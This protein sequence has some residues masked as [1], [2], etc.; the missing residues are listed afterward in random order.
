MN[1]ETMPTNSSHTQDGTTN[2]G[3]SIEP[4]YL[5]S[6]S[7]FQFKNYE[8]IQLHF[9]SPIVC[10]LGNN[11]EGKTNL[12]DAIHYLSFTKSYFH[13]TDAL[14]VRH[15]CDQASVTGEFVRANQPE[16]LHC[17]IRKNQRKIVKRNHK[18]Y[19]RLAEHIGLL[20]CIIITP[21]DIEL[22]WE[23]SEIRRKFMD[24]T[25]SQ[26]SPKYLDYLMKYNQALS[27]RNQILKSYSKS[28]APNEILEPWD[29]QLIQ[30][31]APIFEERKRFFI[32][33]SD[34]FSE[35]YSEISGGKEKGTLNYNSELSSYSMEE[36]LKKNKEKDKILERT[37]G[38]IHKD[39][40][41]FF[42]E[43][44]PIKKFA[45]QGQQKSFLISLKLAQYMIIRGRSAVHPILLLDDLYDK[46]DDLRVSN[47]L[48]WILQK[49]KGQVFIS[50][51][52]ID[53]IPDLL[54]SKSALFQ[55]FV[56][57]DNQCTPLTA[58]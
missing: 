27:Q 43:N 25:I 35:V 52:H 10:F 1:T 58:S 45:S 38:G 54:K 34:I 48:D 15:E 30:Y 16:L 36:I 31:S 21:Y 42:I 56:V 57:A 14:N 44:Q 4:L 26:Y 50:D 41:D 24:A 53:R 33:L 20:P 22:I 55:T 47:L 5:N 37:S 19:E 23:G 28:G 2:H 40:L 3:L 51:T 12:L 13:A 18:E 29:F 32:M 39:D 17:A 11:G 8:A 6:L 7:L 49:I 46:V 9:S